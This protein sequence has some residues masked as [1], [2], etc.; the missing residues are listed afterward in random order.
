M[1]FGRF[2]GFAQKGNN[3]DKAREVVQDLELTVL[4]NITNKVA[5]YWDEKDE[6]TVIDEDKDLMKF[7]KL[8]DS[9]GCPACAQYYT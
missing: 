2:E 3:K 4:R 9:W 1:I 7:Y 5:I 6:T 8:F